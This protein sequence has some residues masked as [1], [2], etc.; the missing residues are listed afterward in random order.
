MLINFRVGVTMD[1]QI[2][3]TKTKTKTKDSIL[4]E[5]QIIKLYLE[6]MS[7]TTIIIITIITIQIRD[8]QFHLALPALGKASLMGNN[9]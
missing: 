9:L 2:I 7:I 5:T 6:I 1:I 8:H 4:M 3:V